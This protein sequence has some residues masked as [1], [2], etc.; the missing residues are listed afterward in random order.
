VSG[1]FQ[2]ISNVWRGFDSF[3]METITK[4]WLLKNSKSPR[5]RTVEDMQAHR[6]RFGASG[7]CFDL[8]IWLMHEFRQ[9][10][11][12]AFYVGNH[13]GTPDAHVAVVAIDSRLRRYL[14]DLGDLWIQPLS[15]ESE[16][17]NMVGFFTGAHINLRLERDTA[18]VE[19]LRPN[20]KRSTQTYDLTPVSEKDFIEAANISQR[21]LSH[22]L[23]EMRVFQEEETVHWEF[24]NFRSF[25]SSLSGLLEESKLDSVEDWAKRIAKMTGIKADYARDCL[26][27]YDQL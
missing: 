1:D 19:Y 23:V 13:I 15:L 20:G 10:G 9:V 17:M 4:A 24:E 11:V 2:K 22:P 12:Q 25:F 27:V 3:P 7:N 14:C 26:L 5:Q 16:A 18:L 21:S 6:L 8:A